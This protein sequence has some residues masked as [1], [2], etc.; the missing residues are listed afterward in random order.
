[1]NKTTIAV[2]NVNFA[3]LNS[4]AT[5]LKSNNKVKDIQKS[6]SGTEGTLSISYDG[7]TDELAE[8]INSNLAAQFDI[9]GVEQGK[10]SLTGK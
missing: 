8:L 7:S 5:S 2:S 1:M 9:T 3:K 10:I 6:L 4:L